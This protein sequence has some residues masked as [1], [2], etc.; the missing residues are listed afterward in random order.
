MYRLPEA[1]RADLAR[2]LGPVLPPKEAAAK[3]RAARVLVTVGDVTT[4][5]MLDE[6]LR[7]RLMVVDN[8]TKRGSVA[9]AVREGLPGDIPVV[10]V[11]NP[12]ARITEDLW[13]AC[14]TALAGT[15]PTLVEVRGEE[16]LATLPCV[17]L[18]PNGSVVAYGQPDEGVV[19]LNV[20][21]AARQR[22]R[23][24]LKQM[25]GP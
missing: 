13:Q 15:Q 18:A 1:L 22:V 25:E 4:Q 23:A 16:D 6:G 12:P 20:N 9:R 3:A 10:N 14:A 2:P 19:L 8:R 11:E 17:L 24:L 7:P 5:T 21:D